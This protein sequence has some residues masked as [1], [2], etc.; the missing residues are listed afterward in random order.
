MNT[1]YQP[2]EVVMLQ[3]MYDTIT[4][5]G[6]WDWLRSFEPHHNEGFMF[7]SDA[8]LARISAEMKYEGHSGFSFAW[9]MQMMQDIAKNGWE[10]HKAQVIAKRG[11]PCPCRREAGI[12]AGWCGNCPCM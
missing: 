6:L 3:D 12:L 7:S 1:L 10:A 4:R 8:T 2:Y 11:P 9:T 5:T